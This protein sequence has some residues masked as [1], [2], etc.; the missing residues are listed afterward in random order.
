MHKPVF[1]KTMT[2]H[3][4]CIK[5]N[6]GAPLIKVTDL[7]KSTKYNECSQPGFLMEKDSIVDVFLG[8]L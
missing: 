8:A 4:E 7:V 3:E 2:T 1:N 6:F 5:Y